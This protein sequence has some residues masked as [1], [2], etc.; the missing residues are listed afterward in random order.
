MIYLGINIYYWDRAEQQ[1]F[2]LWD[3]L[4][5][6]AVRA[7]AQNL[8]GHFWFCSFDARG[9]HIFAWFGTSPEAAPLL[10]DL[11]NRDI[12]VFLDHSPSQ[13]VLAREELEQRHTEC[14]GKTLC[15]PDTLEDIAP[16]NSFVIFEHKEDAYPLWLSRGMADPEKFWNLMDA[17]TFWTMEKT[18]AN[19]IEP[20]VR[21]LG[22]VDRFLKQRG[23]EREAY[24][25]LHSVTLVPPLAERLK[26][27]SEDVRASLRQALSPRNREFLSRFW[28]DKS[29]DGFGFDLE[30][31]MEVITAE[32][33]RSLEQRFRVL[34]EVNH[35]VLGQCGYFVRFHIP[36]VLYGWEHSMQQ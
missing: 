10:R 35:L 34:R 24:W 3:G 19:S 30:P 14:R 4:R 11:L 2:L 21:W 12:S 22:A 23:L 9:P 33:G 32:D 36:M 25:R 31:L 15:Q 1:Q 7:R 27:G 6:C 29:D 16:N 17:L 28:T 5:P 8:A 20:G 18:R 26:N 13:R